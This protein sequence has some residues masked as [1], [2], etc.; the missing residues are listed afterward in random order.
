[1]THVA[2]SLLLPLLFTCRASSA[3]AEL[4]AL[5]LEGGGFRAFASDTGFMAGLMATICGS[6]ATCTLLDSGLLRDVGLVSSVSGSTWFASDLAY[7]N[8][9]RTSVVEAIAAEPH[10]ASAIY[11][12]GFTNPWLQAT[13]IGDLEYCASMPAAKSLI[14]GISQDIELATFFL[15]TGFTWSH[16]V[17]ILLNSTGGISRYATLSS[18]VGEWAKGKVWLAD[19]SAVLP[20]QQEAI[21]HED[22]LLSYPRVG[23]TV[24]STVDLPEFIPAKVGVTWGAPAM[25]EAPQPYV[26]S[27][28]AA[29]VTRLN[30][31]GVVLPFV[32]DLHSASGDLQGTFG[33]NMTRFSSVLPIS[34]VVAASSAFLGEICMDGALVNGVLDD[35]FHGDVTPWA[36][37]APDGLA[38]EAAYKSVAEFSKLAGV[39]Q[40][41]M[42]AA[43]REQLHAVIDA[44]ETDGTG[45]A[46][47]VASGA[48]SVTVVLNSNATND[49]EYVQRL[50]VN[51]SQ[52]SPRVAL[53]FPVFSNPSGAEVREAFDRFHLMQVPEGSRFLKV[54]AVG[55]ISAV[56]AENMF[57]GLKRGRQV[58]INVVNIGSAL[59]IGSLENFKN[60]NL[61][62]QEVVSTL[63][64]AE[65]SELVQ[66]VLLPMLQRRH[67]QQPHN[68][69]V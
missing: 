19:H 67:G 23:Y 34:R 50:F 32:D 10:N 5:A 15:T 39:N 25:A 7:S 12:A 54:F 64:L 8:R 51:G 53:L 44:G 28:V 68:L 35:A 14:S 63:T 36:S 9:F 20:R 3:A 55:S 13:N 65:N 16:F 57:F 27:G 29:A 30:Y 11:G 22:K 17:D 37:A 31:Q 21:V 33:Q 4:T 43:A 1:M 58:Q 2:C 61:L 49:P 24:T 59:T 6:S 38:F 69:F 66:D 48:D 42:D 56:T 62:V 41:S 52:P 40:R 45:I 26:A 47:A 60:Y 18:D 46:W